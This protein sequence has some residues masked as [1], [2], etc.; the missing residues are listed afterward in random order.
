MSVLATIRW[1]EAPQLRVLSRSIPAALALRGR[2]RPGTDGFVTRRSKAKTIRPAGAPLLRLSM[3]GVAGTSLAWR[4]GMK[5]QPMP[6]AHVRPRP[7]S[8][9]R[10]VTQ[11]LV[12][13]L[14]PVGTAFAQSVP[15]VR[16]VRDGT[17][18][19]CFRGEKEVRLTASKG[20]V[21]EVV[22]IEGDRY[23][24]LDSNWYWVMLPTGVWGTR[25]AGWIRG[26]AVE[27]VQ[28]P[29]EPAPAPRASV[30]EVPQAQQARNEPREVATPARASAEPA[31]APAA[32]AVIADVIVN[33]QFGRSELT[34]EAKRRLASAVVMPRANARGVSV[35]VEGH[36]D[37][38]GPEGYNQRLGLA[39]AETVRRY[40]TE[41]FRIP[42][43]QIS[44]VSF[45]E[46]SPVA[47]NTSRE[48][49]ARNRRVLIKGGA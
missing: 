27:H 13:S 38:T 5:T 14:I 40:L 44:V 12:L 49:R 25:P 26:D 39:R 17:E 15:L 29:P 19:S 23:K 36:A 8:L 30:A 47:P 1:P 24:D 41:Q 16:V 6:H 22:Y 48:G 35:A 3:A 31:P 10:A 18:I 46:N 7:W 33:F 9:R 42:A 45:G 43:E 4:T 21:L 34:D 37:W 32:R 28:P 2:G 11:A 20:T